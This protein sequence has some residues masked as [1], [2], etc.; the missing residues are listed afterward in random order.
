MKKFT[1]IREARRSAQD[2][3]S[4]ENV[5]SAAKKPENFVAPDG[6]VH[7]RLVPVKKDVINKDADKHTEGTDPCWDS[8]KQV[9]M[10]KKGGKMVPN[11]VSKEA[12]TQDE[13]DK[14]AKSVGDQ[15]R[16]RQRSDKV[17][18]MSRK[19]A[20]VKEDTVN[21][22]TDLSEAVDFEKMARELDK[23]K[24]KGEDYQKAA[25]FV[26]TVGRNSNVNVQD[27]AMKGL[28]D[29][30]KKMDDFTAR[31]TITKIVKDHGF[32][33][34]GGRLMREKLETDGPKKD[35]NLKT[36]GA[37]A[38]AVGSNNK[39]A[40]SYVARKAKQRQDMNKKND[41]GAAK[42]GLALSVIDREK[43]RIKARKQRDK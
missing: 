43:A 39:A 15:Y 14:F 5:N 36:F 31:T 22:S 16:A 8:H 20:N 21:E 29:L 28:L 33:V 3:L 2:R 34:K 24:S 30:L 9:G 11:C 40:S 10:K 38:R 4:T 26:R 17:S 18:S 35:L 37:M 32:K 25:G 6:K 41:P 23:H 12:M 27:K 42:K 1:E 13:Q 7:T 19:R